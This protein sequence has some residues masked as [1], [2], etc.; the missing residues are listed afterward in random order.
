MRLAVIKRD[1]DLFVPMLSEWLFDPVI[2]A[3]AGLGIAIIAS[4]HNDPWKIEEH[5]WTREKRI[6]C[7]RRADAVHLLLDRFRPSL[8]A[9]L[10]HRATVIPNGVRASSAALEAPVQPRPQRIIGV[11]RLEPQK[12]FDLLINAFALVSKEHPGWHLDIFGEGQQR[13]SLRD[14]IAATGLEGVASLKGTTTEI[15][16]EYLASSI[17]VLPSEF[18]GFGIV[19]LEAKMAALPCIAYGHCN[20]PNELVRDGENGLLVAQDDD[21]QSLA[22]AFRRLMQDEELRGRMGHNARE[23]LAQYL[24]CPDGRSVGGPAARDDSRYAARVRARQSRNRAAPSGPAFLSE[25]GCAPRC[26]G[27][28]FSRRSLPNET[29]PGIAIRAP[30]VTMYGM[31]AWRARSYNLQAAASRCARHGCWTTRSR[32]SP[33][34]CSASPG[35]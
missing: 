18:E 27:S 8:P 2:E 34:R 12:R 17:F 31:P 30:W 11:G 22:Q 10:V 28:K 21:G 23:S 32:C 25:R 5:W 29:T 26:L 4:E 14:L 24:A 3:V 7:F 13:Q 9:D 15:I 16:Q 33:T 20:G 19:V 1:L 35:I 6:A